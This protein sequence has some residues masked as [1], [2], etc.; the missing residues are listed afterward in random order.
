MTEPV[1]AVEGLSTGYGSVGIVHG[2]DLQLEPSSVSV[3][4]GPNGAGKS[5]TCKAL[6]G[7]LPAMSGRIVLQGADITARRAWWRAQHGIF[8]APEGRGIF[9]GLSVDENLRVLLPGAA[10]RD[11]IYERFAVLGQR[12]GIPAGNL[13][14]GEQQMLAIAPMLVHRA[15]VVIADEPTLGLAPRVADVVLELFAEISRQGAAVLLVGESPQ[16]LVEI[17]S[18]VSLLHAGRIIWNGSASSLDTETLQEAYFGAAA[19][20]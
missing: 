19:S 3:I 9:P 1:L 17:A 15:A 16:G 20:T 14:G 11:V 12:R 4:L 7:L 6:A 18:Q 10:D 13:S 2:L 5:T 8:L